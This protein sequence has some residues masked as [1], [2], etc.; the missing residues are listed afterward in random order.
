MTA[1]PIPANRTLW[2]IARISGL[3]GLAVLLGMLFIAPDPTLR[4]FWNL[5]VPIIPV[6]L[7]L[8]PV[9]WRNVCPLSSLNQGSATART[10]D[11]GAFGWL[12]AIGVLLL[13]AMVP[14]RH[15]VFN[16]S[17]PVLAATIMAV[18]GLSWITGRMFASRSGF[19]NSI[20]P[21]LS[22]ERLYGSSP[23]IDVERNR[24]HTCTG[25]VAGCIDVTAR[26]AGVT[27][28]GHKRHPQRWFLSAY[29]I[30]A[31]SFPGFVYGYFTVTEE[32]IASVWGVYTHVLLAAAA[33]YAVLSLAGITSRSTPR[34]MLNICAASAGG[35]YF[36]FASTAIARTLSL[37]SPFEWMLRIALL[38][39]VTAWFWKAVARRT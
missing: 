17:G 39:L 38:T 30:F 32:N 27:A 29:G 10:I 24:C 28:L 31:A 8:N 9:I 37:G 6:T 25:C 2:D 18:G 22:V 35:L 36:W 4:Y 3:V 15:M 33:S 5:A 16:S 7:F 20:C 11:R 14:A 13:F 34:R 23:L 21:V 19:C 26:G 12:T 1:T